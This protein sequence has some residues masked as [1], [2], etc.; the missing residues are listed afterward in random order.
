MLLLVK[1]VVAKGSRKPV[2]NVPSLARS[3]VSTTADAAS[4]QPATLSA[5][6]AGVSC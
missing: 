2:L 6:W 4:Q 3:G 5:F 1:R